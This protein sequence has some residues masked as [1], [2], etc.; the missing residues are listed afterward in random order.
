MLFSQERVRPKI[1]WSKIE[2]RVH[3]VNAILP[4]R[5]KTKNHPV[6]NTVNGTQGKTKNFPRKG[7]TKNYTVESSFNG[8]QGYQAIFPRKSNT[9]NPGNAIF[10]ERERLKI[11]QWTV[12]L[13]VH[14]V[15]GN[16]PRKE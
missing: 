16:F 5:N 11:T 13:T 1:T 14:R 3:R 10:L 9:I 15:P 12:A 4:G 7:K 8:T 6:K 2:L